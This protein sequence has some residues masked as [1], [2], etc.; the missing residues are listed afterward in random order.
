MSLKS[1]H[2]AG[3]GWRVAGGEWRVT[4][5]RD[6]GRDLPPSDSRLFG[7]RLVFFISQIGSAPVQFAAQRLQKR[8]VRQMHQPDCAPA[9]ANRHLVAGAKLGDKLAV[10]AQKCRRR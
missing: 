6:A 3:G 1:D 4:K 7:S 8:T 2:G 10:C 5:S 9:A